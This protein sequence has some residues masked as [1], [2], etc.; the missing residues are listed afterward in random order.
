MVQGDY[1]GKIDQTSYFR[2]DL[3]GSQSWQQDVANTG[4]VIEKTTVPMRVT[5]NGDYHGIM[6][7]LITNGMS[8]QAQQNNYTAELHVEPIGQILRQINVAGR[9][10]DITL[11]SD[12][13]YWLTID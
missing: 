2:S 3:F 4:Q 12:G 5:I 13:N 9:H 11:D 7:F 1:R 6:D 8:R 10:L